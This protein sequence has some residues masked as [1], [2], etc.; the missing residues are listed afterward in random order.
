MAFEQPANLDYSVW[1]SALEDRV[2][3]AC[4]NDWSFTAPGWSFNEQLFRNMQKSSAS[5]YLEN[6]MLKDPNYSLGGYLGKRG[7]EFFTLI[8]GVVLLLFAIALSLAVVPKIRA[9]YSKL[10]CGVCRTRDRPRLKQAAETAPRK[11]IFGIGIPGLAT[12]ALIAVQLTASSRTIVDIDAV[13]CG[14]WLQLYG[15]FYGTT[16][17]AKE[18][19]DPNITSIAWNWRGTQPLLEALEHIHETTEPSNEANPLRALLWG[20]YNQLRTDA[21]Q[22]QA[23]TVKTLDY[24]I[25]QSSGW[26]GMGDEKSTGESTK[27]RTWTEFLVGTANGVAYKSQEY[28]DE[29]AETLVAGF[30]QMEQLLNHFVGQDAALL[31]KSAEAAED[32]ISTVSQINAV[33]GEMTAMWDHLGPTLVSLVKAITGLTIS[34]CILLFAAVPVSS[35]MCMSLY[36]KMKEDKLPSAKDQKMWC[37]MFIGTTICTGACALFCCLSVF[38]LAVG[39]DACDVLEG[40]VFQRGQWNVLGESVLSPPG[41]TDIDVPRILDTCVHPSG[42]GNVAGSL[43]LDIRIADLAADVESAKDI[44]RSTRD[45]LL[46]KETRRIRVSVIETGA[47]DMMDFIVRA[48]SASDPVSTT[49]GDL[50][51]KRKPLLTDIG[52]YGPYFNDNWKVEEQST[53][54][55]IIPATHSD[56]Y[57]FRDLHS[58][59]PTV[60]DTGLGI[61]PVPV[62]FAYDLLN[63]LMPAIVTEGNVP[64]VP[65]SFCSQLGQELGLYTC[66]PGATVITPQMFA[67]W[68]TSMDP[69]QEAW[70]TDLLAATF[71]TDPALGYKAW[72]TILTVGR[73]EYFMNLRVSD[74]QAGLLMKTQVHCPAE[75][76]DCLLYDAIRETKA[77]AVERAHLLNTALERL[78]GLID[79]FVDTVTVG[80][81]DS[82]VASAYDVVE[83]SNCQFEGT[84]LYNAVVVPLCTAVFPSVAVTAIVTGIL[85]IVA[86]LL[87]YSLWIWFHYLADVFDR[88]NGDKSAYDDGNVELADS[89]RRDLFQYYGVAV[90]SAAVTSGAPEAPATTAEAEPRP[91]QQAVVEAPVPEVRHAVKENAEQPVIDTDSSFNSLRP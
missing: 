82:V 34:V 43:A 69:E 72:R 9:T 58:R 49:F 25:D 52:A 37:G 62:N 26:Y 33:L 39:N 65:I 74:T 20:A 15:H 46:D 14:M 66:P 31:Q 27:T 36:N 76:P 30:A 56:T 18:V 77:G 53:L 63:Q 51:D 50:D 54:L 42:D 57:A 73:L 17:L 19:S 38:L 24:W 13:N 88:Y 61:R 5:T 84:A 87:S 80:T 6:Y 35:Y 12:L 68:P 11:F 81:M 83:G 45:V 41:V 7:G 8:L 86:G 23:E 64:N 70:Q 47:A 79:H 89:G 21:T 59:C 29:M 48:P 55:C 60:G 40:A 91:V 75:M 67:T 78:F 71:T 44:V 4:G 32:A 28:K 3:S 22:L 10:C 85:T 90:P 2:Q 16:D 1:R